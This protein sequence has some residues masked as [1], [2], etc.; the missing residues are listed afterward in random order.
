MS[1]YLRALF[2]AQGIFYGWKLVGLSVLVVGVATA[3]IWGGVGVWVKALEQQFGWSRTQLTGA[4]S[5]A[6]LQGSILGPIIGFVIDRIGTRRTVLFG[7]LLVG[8]GFVLFSQTSNLP[9]FYIAFGFIM[10]GSA[11]GTWLPM[12]TAL[13]KWFVRKRTT[14]M[15]I[16]GEG[17]FLGGIVLVPALAWAVVPEHAGWRITA[18]GIGIIFLVFAWPVTRLIRNSPEESGDY[19]DGDP[20]PGSSI[21]EQ[22]AEADPETRQEPQFT[23]R[24]AVRTPAFWFITLGQGLSVMLTATIIVHLVPML[25]D[26]GISLQMASFVW[27][28]Q[29]V[30]GAV[31][32]IVGGIAG[33][34]V[35]KNIALAVFVAIQAGTFGMAVLIHDVPMAMLFGVLYGV[36]FG[37]SNPLATAIRGD[38]FGQRAFGT[39]TGLSMAPMFI[40]ML[41]APIFAAAVFDARGSYFFPFVVLAALGGLGAVFFLLAK[42]PVYVGASQSTIEEGIRPSDAL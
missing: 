1:Q 24:Q 40:F 27:S 3:P 37:G 22:A 21:A 5:L 36:G 42:R 38:Y 6:Q 28:V 2:P 10:V 17:Y 12:M 15:A 26:Q 4:F 8:L 20:P 11:S 18:L 39:I 30:F 25:T 31:F 41:L 16:A 34:R 13:N 19:P 35:P 23:A 29:M 9:M 7:L 32:Q 14:A 33:D